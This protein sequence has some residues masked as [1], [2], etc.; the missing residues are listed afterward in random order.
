[1]TLKT[2]R[3]MIIKIDMEMDHGYIAI[4]VGNIADRVIDHVI[5]SKICQQF[6][7]L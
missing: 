7:L 1:M 2:N 6:E 5:V 3:D 4:Q